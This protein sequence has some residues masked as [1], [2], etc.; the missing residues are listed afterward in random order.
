MGW[1]AWFEKEFDRRIDRTKQVE[2]V[3][4]FSYLKG[5]DFS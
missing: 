5:M 3:G 4:E 1:E 2:C